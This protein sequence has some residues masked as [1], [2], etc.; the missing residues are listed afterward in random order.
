[1]RARRE[2][3]RHT[4][5]KS[6]HILR[7]SLIIAPT[8]QP[9]SILDE[10]DSM[11]THASAGEVSVHGCPGPIHER[12]RGG[13]GGAVREMGDRADFSAPFT[14][15]IRGGTGRRASGCAASGCAGW[16]LGNASAAQGAR[17]A[18]FTHA[19]DTVWYWCRCSTRGW[20][21]CYRALSLRQSSEG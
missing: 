19:A 10:R 17:G 14:R 7:T 13:F 5:I 20:G 12:R 4:D 3:G 2:R 18:P 9:R 1:M 6:P 8:K 16:F 21:E 11:R 15:W